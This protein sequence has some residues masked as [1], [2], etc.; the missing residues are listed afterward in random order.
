MKIPAFFGFRQKFRFL[1]VTKTHTHG[2]IPNSHILS[3]KILT[4]YILIS[5]LE[6]KKVE[7]GTLRKYYTDKVHTHKQCPNEENFIATGVI[8]HLRARKTF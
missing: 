1:G 7:K 2:K 8:S 3:L 4:F 5:F 6:E